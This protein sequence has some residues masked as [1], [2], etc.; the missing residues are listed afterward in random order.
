LS[1]TEEAPV[2]DET[3]IDAFGD[4]TVAERVSVDLGMP[5]MIGVEEGGNL[6]LYS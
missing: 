4:A 2:D 6:R 3:G 1:T 5:W